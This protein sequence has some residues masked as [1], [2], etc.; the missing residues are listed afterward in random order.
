MGPASKDDKYLTI[1]GST[2]PSNNEIKLNRGIAAITTETS[3]SSESELRKNENIFCVGPS[4]VSKAQLST[5]LYYKF[6]TNKRT[7][8]ESDDTEIIEGKNYYI[9][10]ND[11][12]YTKV[13]NP[14]LGEIGSYWEETLTIIPAH[15]YYEMGDEEALYVSESKNEDNSLVLTGDSKNYWIYYGSDKE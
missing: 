13:E 8:I 9:K 4:Y 15:S 1:D 2:F 6:I 12:E 14:V 7:F 11:N 10:N 3:I 5:C